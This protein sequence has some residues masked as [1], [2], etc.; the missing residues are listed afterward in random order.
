M[1]RYKM[2]KQKYSLLGIDG[3]AFSIMGYVT[4][5][6]KREEKSVDEMTIYMTKATRGTYESLLAVSQ[7]AINDLVYD[8]EDNDKN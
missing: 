3:N 5:C 2:A 4:D 7:Q 8:G 1:Q 6:M